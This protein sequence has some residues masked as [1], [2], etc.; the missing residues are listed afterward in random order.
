MTQLI[1]QSVLNKAHKDKFRM[2]VTLPKALRDINVSQNRA[3]DKVLRDS[4]QFSVYGVLSPAVNVPA[5]EIKFG[6][7]S[8]NYTSFARPDY[9]NISVNFTVD[10]EYN[11][12]WVI[13]KW[14]NLLNNNTE[15]FFYA[16]KYPVE[17]APYS[18][19]ATNITVYGL[20]EY[21]NPRIQFNYIGCLP[22]GLG[23]IAYN[24][25]DDGQIES[26]FQFAFSQLETKLL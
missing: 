9:D 14:I 13:Y 16:E 5:V 19:Y 8:F 10:N 21:N 11:N 4:L 17:N 23:E 1:R 22:I 20:D 7:Q 12:Y 3:N 18:E 26:I 24:N 15:G 25:R 2:V 6:G